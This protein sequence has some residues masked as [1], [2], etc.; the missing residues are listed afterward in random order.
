MALTD[1][2]ETPLPV[3]YT[4]FSQGPRAAE[5]DALGNLFKT[6]AN[7]AD[8]GI[9][10]ADRQKKSDITD[11]ILSQ[12]ETI[13]EEFGVSSATDTEVDA[14]STEAAARPPA[15]SRAY[16]NLDTLQNA[17]V[18]GA[19]KESHYWARLNVMVRQLRAKYPGYRQ[20]I[21]GMVASVVGARPANALRSALFQE[22]DEVKRAQANN[23]LGKLEDWAI[24]SGDLPVDYFDRQAAG[25]PYTYEELGVHVASRTKVKSDAESRQRELSLKISQNNVDKVEFEN[26]YRLDATQ[27]VHSLLEDS[28]KVFGKNFA[29]ISQKVKV[30]QQQMAAGIPVNQLEVNQLIG[31][32]ASLRTEAELALTEQFNRS[33]DGSPDHSYAAH[34]DQATQ[35]AIIQ[36]ALAPLDIIS[37]SL[38]DKDNPYAIINS[39]SAWLE[40]TKIQN[41]AAV[42]QEAPILGMLGAISDLAGPGVAQYIAGLG[43]SPEALTK[44]LLDLSNSKAFLGEGDIVEAMDRGEQVGAKADYYNGLA[45]SWLKLSRDIDSGEV[46]LEMLQNSVQYMFGNDAN[47]LLSKMDPGSRVMWYNKVASPEVTN[48]MLKLRDMGD[49][50][51]WNTYQDWVKGAFVNIFAQEMNQ[52]NSTNAILSGNMSMVQGA[53][54]WDP[55]T[56]S[57]KAD[58][59]VLGSGG[60]LTWLAQNMPGAVWNTE[61]Q[62]L[63]SAIAGIKPIIE[64]NGGEVEAELALLLQQMGFTGQGIQ[65]AMLEELMNNV[66]IQE[67]P[68]D[69]E[70]AE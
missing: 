42:L 69:P 59:S 24:K 41:Q 14:E 44:A 58:V 53:I 27:F 64:E 22:W 23:P 28:S 16:Q 62:T 57:F 2:T 18:K 46:P 1:N 49:E 10:E 31:Q 34:L 38:A 3:D 19:I 13:Q 48:Q 65:G 55:D 66:P 36:Q 68:A 45:Q 12:V 6:T 8:M 39:A 61:M 9:K 37:N 5:N 47:L 26:S 25:D 17:Y 40:A 52:L 67:N 15:L 50:Q 33:W 60:A 63:N 54:T 70:E 7:V 43:E 11:D 29:E 30:V 21:D 51:S 20:D 4:G 35:Q 32:M 56:S